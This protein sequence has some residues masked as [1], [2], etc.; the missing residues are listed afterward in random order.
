M[1][2]KKT[3]RTTKP[4]TKT[5]YIALAIE[6]FDYLITADSSESAEDAS[7]TLKENYGI[8]NADIKVLEVVMPAVHETAPD[9]KTTKVTI[10]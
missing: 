8:D 1:T 7:Q 9:I 5:F 2:T 4:T 6:D 3:K 10:K